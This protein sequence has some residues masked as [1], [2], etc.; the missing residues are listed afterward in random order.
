MSNSKKMVLAAF[1]Q[2]QNGSNFPASWRHPAAATDYTSAEYYQRIA[3]EL[4]A[5]RFD[6]AFI[7]D[8]LALPDKYGDSFEETVRYGIRPVKIDPGPVMMAMGLAT[9][10]I[11]LAATY[12]TTYNEPFHIARTIGTMDLLLKGRA[13]WNVVTSLNDSEAANFGRGKHLAHDMRYDRAE[14][15]M[16]VVLG[17]WDSW[18]DDAMIIDKQNGIFAAPE[19]VRAL[20]HAGKIFGSRGPLPVP[21]SQQGRPVI[22][23]AG[24]SERGRRF[25][26]RWGE[27]IFVQFPNVPVGQKLYKSLKGMFGDAGREQAGAKVVTAVFAV[28]GETRAMAEEKIAVLDSLYKP[29]DALVLLSEMCNFDFIGKELDEPISPAEI[30]TMNGNTS[31][32]DR[33][34]DFSGRPDPSI[35]DFLKHTN[36]ATIREFPMFY[37]TPSDVADQM[38]EWFVGDVCDGFVLAAT[39]VPGTYEDFCRL[40][41]PEL[42]RRGLAR[43]EYSGSTLREHLGL[44]K[45]AVGD[46]R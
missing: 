40:V 34:V 2:A 22:L 16:E 10:K 26:A 8:R 11:G 33:V 6:L 17:H 24:S 32:R 3:R 45:A 39:H 46:W 9:Q 44:K 15:F 25:A 18:D 41:V 27:L 5:A 14:E 38:E 19:K 12:S 36:R 37:G 43:T 35:A 23:Q 20:N 30:A 29:I 42:Q 13:G 31:I 7:D 28:V 1:L 4:E 21:R